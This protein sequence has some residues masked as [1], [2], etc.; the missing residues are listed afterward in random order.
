MSH[1]FP[2]LQKSYLNLTSK[3]LMMTRPWKLTCKRY[4]GAHHPLSPVIKLGTHHARK[5]KRNK[6]KSC[7][8]IVFVLSSLSN[9]YYG[10]AFSRIM[11]Y[12]TLEYVFLSPLQSPG[13]HPPYASGCCDRMTSIFVWLVCLAGM[14]VFAQLLAI[15]WWVYTS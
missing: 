14:P 13:L 4:L 7:S 10:S 2:S 8:N 1:V 6:G 12:F 3:G 15:E 5:K 9:A 11:V